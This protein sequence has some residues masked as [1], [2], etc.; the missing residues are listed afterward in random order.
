MPFLCLMQERPVDQTNAE[1]CSMQLLP[2]IPLPE[3]Y[4][5]R[6]LHICG[7]K[8]LTWMAG[9]RYCFAVLWR[10]LLLNSTVTLSRSQHIK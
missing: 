8:Q 3:R 2:V 4:S 5:L 7:G 9:G 6:R 1:R 10:S